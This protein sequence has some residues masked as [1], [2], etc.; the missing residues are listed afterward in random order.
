V[1]L[2]MMTTMMSANCGESNG[3]N[4]PGRHRHTETKQPFTRS[5]LGFGTGET[6]ARIRHGRDQGSDSARGFTPPTRAWICPCRPGS[7][8]P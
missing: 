3:D 8:C 7:S 4:H 2:L 1:L 5:A 6:K